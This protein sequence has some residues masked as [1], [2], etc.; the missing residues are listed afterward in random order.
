M[1]SIRDSIE[2]ENFDA[3]LVQRKETEKLD[4]TSVRNLGHASPALCL[5][6]D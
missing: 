3:I 4:H 2:S 1:L 5:D 6:Y